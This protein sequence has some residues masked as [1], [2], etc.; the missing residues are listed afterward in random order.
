MNYAMARQMQSHAGKEGGWHYTIQ[1]DDQV[2]RHSCC[3][4]CDRADDGHDTAEEAYECVYRYALRLAEKWERCEYPE[5][6]GCVVCDAPVKQ[7][8]RWQGAVP[9]WPEDAPF[10]DEH[11][12][13]AHV[14]ERVNRPGQVT[15][16]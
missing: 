2:W 15:Y 13:T 16:S 9:G 5:W 3:R 8:A 12:T 6:R 11:L 10:C 4:E 14:V 7:G 1:N